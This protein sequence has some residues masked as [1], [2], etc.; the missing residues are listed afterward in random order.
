VQKIRSPEKPGGIERRFAKIIWHLL[1]EGWGRITAE[2]FLVGPLNDENDET[3]P[4][5]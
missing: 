4:G 3:G 2:G 5:H 1:F